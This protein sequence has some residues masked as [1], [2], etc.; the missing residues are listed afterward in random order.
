MI[1]WSS[2][3]DARAKATLRFEKSSSFS[4]PVA[5]N[6]S[7]HQPAIPGC[8]LPVGQF[9]KIPRSRAAFQ[10]DRI[11]PNYCARSGTIASA[12]SSRRLMSGVQRTPRIRMFL[13]WTVKR[14]FKRFGACS[15][16]SDVISRHQIVS[17]HIR[18]RRPPQTKESGRT[19]RRAHLRRPTQPRIDE[20]SCWY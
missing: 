13:Q 4:F 14:R 1:G 15:M 17:G 20:V 2:A 5:R 11:S 7:R 8:H 19:G 6:R 9:Q 16:T 12:P 10:T 18:A 3:G